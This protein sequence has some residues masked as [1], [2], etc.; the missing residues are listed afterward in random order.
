VEERHEPIERAGETR[1][2]ARLRLELLPEGPELTGL[3][4][5]Q[6]EDA[7]GCARL[8]LSLPLPPVAGVDEDVPRVDLHHVVHQQHLE[9]ARQVDGDLRMLRQ[10]QRHHRHMPGVL[11]GV[12]EPLASAGCRSGAAP[13]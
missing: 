10:H 6:P 9:H 7:L 3:V 4:V 2:G 13:A 5:Q 12:L 11:G 1:L 8:G